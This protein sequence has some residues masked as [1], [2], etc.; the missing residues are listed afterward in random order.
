M[1][2]RDPADF[3]CALPTSRTA[4]I[5]APGRTL[6][7]TI[8]RSRPGESL[9]GAFRGCLCAPDDAAQGLQC[10]Q[11]FARPTFSFVL[12]LALTLPL[13]AGGAIATALTGLNIGEIHH[14]ARQ[15][16][17]ATETKPPEDLV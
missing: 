1:A 4:L 6:P 7:N 8:G 15:R 17:H 12:F 16:M 10:L 2:I 5:C 3:G 11:E 9:C 13:L 14:H